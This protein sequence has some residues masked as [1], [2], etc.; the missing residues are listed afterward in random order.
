[1]AS[2]KT[3]KEALEPFQNPKAGLD[4]EYVDSTGQVQRGKLM[5][6]PLFKLN[7][8]E[9][10]EGRD[11]LLFT[12]RHGKGRRGTIDLSSE[13]GV[14]WKWITYRGSM[15][16]PPSLAKLI[17]EHPDEEEDEDGNISIICV[18]GSKEHEFQEASGSD[19]ETDNNLVTFDC[20]RSKEPVGRV[21]RKKEL[22]ALERALNL[23]HDE[24]VFAHRD[25]GKS[26]PLSPLTRSYIS[27]DRLQ[28]V[29]DIERLRSEV[30][31][32]LDKSHESREMAQIVL[33]DIARAID[34]LFDTVR[35]REQ[36]LRINESPGPYDSP[37]LTSEDNPSNLNLSEPLGAPRNSTLASPRG[38]NP[39]DPEK[40]KPSKGTVQELEFEG[41]VSIP[42][43]QPVK[44]RYVMA[45]LESME[46]DAYQSAQLGADPLL[47]P[48]HSNLHSQDSVVESPDPPRI[49]H[50]NQGVAQ[51]SVNVTPF[52]HLVR[53]SV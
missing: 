12:L 30:E 53:T 48:T 40:E 19:D 45:G 23:Y 43:I 49:I 33:D 52:H 6:K 44:P 36:E 46:L 31:Q 4:I 34:I 26:H 50:S 37:T 13:G 17:E 29:S 28:L 8:R 2:K 24:I 15:K 5:S 9:K 27:K 20:L 32:E 7:T 10:A 14:G 35:T 1:M 21:V 38:G 51:P 22:I 42:V 39:L 41:D 18:P 25:H 47:N 16:N 11:A 3:L